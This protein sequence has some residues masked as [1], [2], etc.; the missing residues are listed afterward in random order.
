[1]T[2]CVTSKYKYHSVKLVHLYRPLSSLYLNE[3]KECSTFN[4][5]CLY[6]F[7]LSG[8]LGISILWGNKP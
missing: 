8:K 2:G 7:N 6:S 5:I 4:K 1:M 3:I